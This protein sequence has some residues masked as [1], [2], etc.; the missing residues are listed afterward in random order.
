MSKNALREN[1]VLLVAYYYT[2]LESW[3]QKIARTINSKIFHNSTADFS[4]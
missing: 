1:F 4:K 2:D 3:Q